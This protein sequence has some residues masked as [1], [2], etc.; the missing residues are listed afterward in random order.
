MNDVLVVK[1]LQVHF[2]LE[3]TSVKAVDGVSFNVHKGETLAL[4]QTY[5]SCQR[6]N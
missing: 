5:L 2:I 4:N 3:N 1:D 6:K